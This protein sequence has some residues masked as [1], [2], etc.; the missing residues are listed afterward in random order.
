MRKL[1]YK[2]I[3]ILMLITLSCIGIIAYFIS[4]F[5]LKND[6]SI[7]YIDCEV[8]ENFNGF[9]KKDVSVKNTGTADAYIRA[10]IIVNWIDSSGNINGGESPIEGI[11]YDLKLGSE[12]TKES[13]GYYYY[14]KKVKPKEN[15][16]T[17]IEE[18]T[19]I[20]GNSNDK[21]SVKVLASAVQAN[22]NKTSELWGIKIEE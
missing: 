2:N 8:E 11:N 21:L 6:F 18:C 15:T 12:W 4:F 5:S 22:P 14:H 10:D 3:G 19:V 13:D 20:S 1:N 7:G 9:A 16:G 17:L